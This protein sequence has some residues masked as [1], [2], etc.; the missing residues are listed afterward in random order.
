MDKQDIEKAK[1]RCLKEWENV[2]DPPCH[3]SDPDWKPCEIC[4]GTSKDDDYLNGIY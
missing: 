1:A 3:P 4:D 2:N